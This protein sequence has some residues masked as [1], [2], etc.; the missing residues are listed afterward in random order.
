MSEP[1]SFI[2][3]PGPEWIQQISGW[4]WACYPN[5]SFPRTCKRTWA[6]YTGKVLNMD[7]ST[8]VQNQR[9]VNIVSAATLLRLRGTHWHAAS[10]F[11]CYRSRALTNSKLWAGI[12]LPDYCPSRRLVMT[13]LKQEPGGRKLSRTVEEWMLLTVL[14][15]GSF[16]LLFYT[17]QEPPT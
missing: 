7:S 5:V 12:N 13:E 10:S 15:C 8:P 3:E 11:A 6:T 1:K 17:S 4:I 2:C 14:L 9:E 16:S